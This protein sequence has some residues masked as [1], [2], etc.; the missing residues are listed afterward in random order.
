MCV[1][2]EKL[3]LRGFVNSSLGIFKLLPQSSVVVVVV[4]V[5][6]ADPAADELVRRIDREDRD[7]PKSA[8]SP[9]PKTP[10]KAPPK[11]VPPPPAKPPP[12]EILQ[13]AEGA[14]RSRWEAA[15]HTVP[16][17]GYPPPDAMSLGHGDLQRAL[18]IL[19]RAMDDGLDLS[20]DF[21]GWTV[22]QRRS[23]VQA[24]GGVLP[25]TTP[26]VGA[27]AAEHGAADPAPEPPADLD[28]PPSV[29]VASSAAA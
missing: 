24:L 9:A 13:G 12:K 26:A 22:L 4:V 10:P 17:T 1:P 19:R 6:S 27:E 18:A 29:Q 11:K 28:A 15:G 14:A 20:G 7:G 25:A 21:A 3:Q 23:L 16:V 5:S 8:A 2:Q